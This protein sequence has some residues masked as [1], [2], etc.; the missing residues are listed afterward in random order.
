M[1]IVGIVLGDKKGYWPDYK[2]VLHY[3]LRD[4][5]YAIK[6]PVVVIHNYPDVISHHRDNGDRVLGVRHVGEKGL[7]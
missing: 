4:P 1:S 3:L 2:H 5:V 6:L 7:D